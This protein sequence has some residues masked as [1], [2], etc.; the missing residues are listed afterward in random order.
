MIKKQPFA[1]RLVI[2][3]VALMG[4]F[5][6]NGTSDD[7]FCP[8][9]YEAGV[10]GPLN[11]TSAFTTIDTFSDPGGTQRDDL[12]ISSF[13]NSIKDSGGENVIG[14]FEDYLWLPESRALAR[15]IPTPSTRIPMLSDLPIWATGQREPSGPTA[16]TGC[17]MAFSP[18]KP[19]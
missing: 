4:S 6:S 12:L 2:V 10:L 1:V 18:S 14:F 3:A 7:G 15:S 19:S 9:V 16:L 17:P 13:F 8:R 11:F 5:C